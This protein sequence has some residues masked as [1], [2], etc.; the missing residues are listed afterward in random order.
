LTLPALA[1]TPEP[2]AVATP[3]G[4]LAAPVATQE[5]P[6]IVIDT[7]EGTV[8]IP[9]DETPSAD[10]SITLTAVQLILIV[11]AALFAGT[12]SSGGIAYFIMQDASRVK[13]VEQLGNSVPRETA[14]K[15][16]AIVDVFTP[17]LVLVKEAFDHRPYE[18]KIASGV[19][20]AFAAERQYQRDT[21]DAQRSNKG[22][23]LVP[24]PTNSVD[25]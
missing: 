24:A 1:Q 2:T 13:M 4:T 10:G 7:G 16:V 19:T 17:I 11:V 5:A 15:I 25:G 22:L 6:A 20:Q 9:V 23:N 18:D 21:L 14:D 12:I 3:D 8:T